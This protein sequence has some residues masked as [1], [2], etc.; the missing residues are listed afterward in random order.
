MQITQRTSKP[1]E[2]VEHLVAFVDGSYFPPNG[3]NVETK[4]NSENQSRKRKQVE[5]PDGWSHRVGIRSRAGE[6]RTRNQRCYGQTRAPARAMGISEETT[7]IHGELTAIQKLTQSRPDKTGA[8]LTVRGGGASF[9][10]C[11]RGSEQLW[12][13]VSSIHRAMVS[14]FA[15]VKAHEDSL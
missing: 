2:Y 1:E 12:P 13:L 4:E 10:T 6:R 9:A 8:W 3:C 5:V 11:Y 15:H 7:K 14:M